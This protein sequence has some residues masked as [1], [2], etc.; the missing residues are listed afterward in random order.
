MSTAN[1]KM[2]NPEREQ[3]PVHPKKFML[4]V[5]LVSVTMLFAAFTSGMIV[6]RG[7]GNWT[8]FII[9]GIFT[10]TTI[11]AALSSVTM[12][13]AYFA[14]KKNNLQALKIALFLTLALG[15]TFSIGQYYGYKA[16][17][18]M[19]VFLVGN[20][21]ESFFYVVTGVH[22]LHIIGGI[23]Y[24]A[25]VLIRSLQNKVHAGNML[26]INL[27]T[28]YWHFVGGLWIYLFIIL[29]VLR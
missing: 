29:N 7:D 13:W 27:C 8:Y 22:L 15:I 25:Y 12:Q 21:S 18:A 17:V 19:H 6:R 23:L 11:V 28:T 24:L 5:F 20:P 9:P 26:S 10:F 16:L 4:W 14:A 1:L 2:A 3:Y